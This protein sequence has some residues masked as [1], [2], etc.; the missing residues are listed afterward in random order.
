MD[1]SRSLI[2]KDA[3]GGLTA[4][5]N[6]RSYTEEME[7]SAADGFRHLIMPSVGREGIMKNINML[8]SMLL[9]VSTLGFFES[10]QAGILFQDDFNN[11]VYIDPAKWVFGL[12]YIGQWDQTNFELRNMGGMSEIPVFAY[13]KGITTPKSF[14]LQADVL[15]KHDYFGNTDRGYIGFFWGQLQQNWN[16]TYLDLQ[17]DK[18]T[19]WSTNGTG[20]YNTNYQLVNWWYHL[21]VTVD[22]VQNIIKINLGNDS[23]IF[24][25]DEY[26]NINKNLGGSIGLLSWGDDVVWDNVKLTIPDV[27]PP[28]P[29]P[30]TLL[31]FISGLAWLSGIARRRTEY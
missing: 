31:L 5:V 28:V 22:D 21:S 6:A 7:L 4:P 14:T 10:A 12:N 29:V 25:G 11:D 19:S 15:V 17:N 13:F 30:S 26:Y 23:N 27:T 3:N 2:I 18:I 16:M 8:L 1:T 20:L 24:S 9:A